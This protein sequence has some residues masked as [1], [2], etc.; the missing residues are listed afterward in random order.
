MAFVHSYPKPQKEFEIA[1]SV[2]IPRHSLFVPLWNFRGKQLIFFHIPGFS[3]QGVIFGHE[4]SSLL[5]LVLHC[6]ILPQSA[7][8]HLLH[9]CCQEWS[10]PRCSLSCGGNLNA[11]DGDDEARD[12][13]ALLITA[14][15]IAFA[16]VINSCHK[17]L[18]QYNTS[19]IKNAFFSVFEIYVS[20]WIFMSF[21]HDKVRQRGWTLHWCP[22]SLSKSAIRI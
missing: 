1:G 13:K 17:W 2:W 5:S 12:G 21:L 11:E 3:V 18:H 22:Y 20:A 10:R 4:P 7:P 15:V 19:P 8:L 6:P 16:F 9:S 14:F